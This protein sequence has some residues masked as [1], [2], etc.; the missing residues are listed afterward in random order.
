LSL[1]SHEHTR[2]TAK[3]SA[4]ADREQ[5]LAALHEFADERKHIF[6]VHA[7]L[8]REAAGLPFRLRAFCVSSKQI[9]GEPL[10]VWGDDYSRNTNHQQN[11]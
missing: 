3:Q 2:C 5:E 9:R 6:I 10:G 1:S 11:V 4:G 7:R 8:L